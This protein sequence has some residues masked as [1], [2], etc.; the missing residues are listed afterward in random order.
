MCR[1]RLERLRISSGRRVSCRCHAS[2]DEREQI[3]FFDTV[4]IP[5][6]TIIPPNFGTGPGRFTL[7]MHF[8]KAFVRG[9]KSEGPG[10]SPAGRSGGVH[11]YSLTFSVYARNIFNNVNLAT[12]IG[13]LNSPL[14]GQSNA[15][16]GRPYSSSSANRRI[17]LQVTFNF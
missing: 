11:R 15:L 7:N 16:A 8:S 13:N 14:F 9:K 2:S 3:C 12:P 17:D 5:G 6:E 4:P 1:Q 10:A